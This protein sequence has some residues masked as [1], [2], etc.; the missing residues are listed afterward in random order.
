MKKRCFIVGSGEFEG[1]AVTSVL[2]DEGDLVTI[3]PGPEDLLI[4]ADGGY[5]YLQ[6]LGMEP[7]VLLGDFDSLAIVPEHEHLIRHSP[8]KDDTDMALAV[9]YAEKEG[10]CSFFLYGG[11]GGRL[12]HTLANLQLLTRLSRDGMEGYL[13]GQGKIITA[14]TNSGISFSDK[15]VGIV[16]VFCMGDQATGVYESGL[17]YTLENACLTSDR[18]LGVSNEF[19][20]VSSRIA[21]QKGTLLILWDAENGLPLKDENN[22]DSFGNDNKTGNGN[23]NR[24]TDRN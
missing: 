9:A 19:T 21:V 7:D 12:D 14:V 13:I 2:G 17:K 24:N 18:A 1:F 16:S 20:G 3:S 5:R 22:T 11:M 4:A 10:F 15:A 6:K 8:I 23:K